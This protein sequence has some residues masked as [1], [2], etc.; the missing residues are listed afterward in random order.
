MKNLNVTIIGA[1]GITSYVLPALVRAFNLSGHIIDADRVEKRN[2]DRQVFTERHVGKLKAEALVQHNNAMLLPVG[3][4][5][6]KNSGAASPHWFR[7]A[8]LIIVCVDNHPARREAIEFAIAWGIPIV[9]PANEYSTSQCLFWHPKMGQEL[10]PLNRYPNMATSNEGSPTD[11]TSEESVQASPQL[12]IA[13]QVAAAFCNYMIQQW[14]G[15][16]GVLTQDRLDQ[17]N[18]PLYTPIEYQSTVGAMESVTISDL[19]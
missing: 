17:H 18:W 6:T 13:N 5:L 1:G 9:L 3:Q 14:M 16:K 10:N 12:P 2:L 4:W 7:D 11:C 8:D 19:V 15:E